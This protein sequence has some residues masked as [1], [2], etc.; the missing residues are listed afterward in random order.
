MLDK[1]AT[2]G[3]HRR[4]KYFGVG[5]LFVAPPKRSSFNDFDADRPP[6]FFWLCEKCARRE[7]EITLKRLPVIVGPTARRTA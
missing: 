1:C 7:N 3:C 5:L 2:K 4:F 6:E